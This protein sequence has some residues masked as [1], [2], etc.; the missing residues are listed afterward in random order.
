MN[1]Y[2]GTSSC[3]P[4]DELSSFH[5]RDEL[6]GLDTA[7]QRRAFKLRVMKGL[8]IDF[9]MRKR[10]LLDAL[11]KGGSTSAARFEAML[12]HWSRWAAT[13]SSWPLRADGSG[14]AFMVYGLWCQI[15]IGKDSFARMK[16][17]F[18]M[19]SLNGFE[20]KSKGRGRLR[21][22]GFWCEL[23]KSCWV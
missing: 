12:L 17:I 10:Q 15:F 3:Q 1:T 21:I 6:E 22:S 13:C 2:D 9:R 19:S 23:Q 20:R 11:S 16:R 8:L 4:H 18:D 5:T 14:L 7:A